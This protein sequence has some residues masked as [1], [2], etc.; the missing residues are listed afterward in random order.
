MKTDRQTDQQLEGEHTHFTLTQ[1]ITIGF[2]DPRDGWRHMVENRWPEERVSGLMTITLSF[3]HEFTDLCF[4]MSSL[5]GVLNINQYP[6]APGGR[7]NLS[8]KV[9]ES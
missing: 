3:F 1:Q 2:T 7:S 6:A 5:I 9:K 4:Q 8:G